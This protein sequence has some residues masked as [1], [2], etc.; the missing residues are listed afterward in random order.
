MTI[1]SLSSAAS[2]Q[3]ELAAMFA[4]DLH[5]DVPTPE[6]DLVA[7]GRLDS[8]GVVELLL[9]LEKR[10]G[11]RV[12]MEDL[13]IDPFRSLATLTAFITTRRNGGH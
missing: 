8:L 10:F 4:K 11:L 13:E 5:I 12:D 6:T 1:A 3:A 7:T 9:Q 2:V